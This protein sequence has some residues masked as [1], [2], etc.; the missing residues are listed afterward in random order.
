M[1][2]GSILEY[3]LVCNMP[4]IRIHSPQSCFRPW[5]WQIRQLN[6][7]NQR[8]HSSSFIRNI[9]GW[10]WAIY[11]YIWLPIAYSRIKNGM[12]TWIFFVVDTYFDSKL[13]ISTS[14]MD[15]ITTKTTKLNISDDT[16]TI[17]IFLLMFFFFSNCTVFCYTDGRFV[18]TSTLFINMEQF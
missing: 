4:G 6:H 17:T 16:L 8:R 5:W 9:R 1:C 7:S 14:Y 10:F 3:I 18:V 2:M 11:C 12:C 15:T 13:S